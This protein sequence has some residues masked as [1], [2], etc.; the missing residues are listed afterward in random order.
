MSPPSKA[1]N[2]AVMAS[3]PLNSGCV[4]AMVLIVGIICAGG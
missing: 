2:G 1:L 3:F 4:A